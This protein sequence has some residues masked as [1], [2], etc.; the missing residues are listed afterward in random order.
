MSF[1]SQTFNGTCTG[2]LIPKAV[3]QTACHQL[4][5]FLYLAAL[6]HTTRDLKS[7]TPCNPSFREEALLSARFCNC[8]SKSQCVTGSDHNQDCV[9][10]QQQTQEVYTLQVSTQTF[11]SLVYCIRA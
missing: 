11:L 7:V 9:V 5:D 10:T 6:I 1:P 8:K 3:W 2:K 4:H